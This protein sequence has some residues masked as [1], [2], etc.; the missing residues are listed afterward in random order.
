MVSFRLLTCNQNAYATLNFYGSAC[1][2]FGAKRPNHGPFTVTID[3]GS[4]SSFDGLSD[5]D[6]FQQLL[7]SKTDFDL[8]NHTITVTNGDQQGKFV[9]IDYIIFTTGDGYD[10][11]YEPVAFQ[12]NP[13]RNSDAGNNSTFDDTDA[14]ITYSGSDWNL[15]SNS[16]LS[17]QY[18]NDTFQ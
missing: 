17:N 11:S 12:L 3:N 8:G 1:Y 2:L 9:D 18:H 4:P 16:V 15:Q 14:S 13:R 10:S 7:F 6:Q 5:P